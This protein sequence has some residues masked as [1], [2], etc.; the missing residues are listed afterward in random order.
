MATHHLCNVLIILCIFFIIII[1]LTSIDGIDY[2]EIAGNVSLHHRDVV[3]CQV[4]DA[5]L[6]DNILEEPETFS[7]S[8][9][10]RGN[11]PKASFIHY[12]RTI[13]IVDDESKM[14]IILC[15]DL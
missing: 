2:I 14:H 9:Y 6:D 12:K 10:Q 13:T 15:I 7:L 11:T 8:V 4:F 5:I 3:A 1:I